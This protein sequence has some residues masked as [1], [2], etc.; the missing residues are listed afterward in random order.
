M[1]PQKYFLA[2]RIFSG[3][4][5]IPK[6]PTPEY[7]PDKYPE[8]SRQYFRISG[9]TR[10]SMLDHDPAKATT[11][12]SLARSRLTTTRPGDGQPGQ[13]PARLTTGRAD[14][15]RR[16]CGNA[17]KVRFWQLTAGH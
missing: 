7:C 5:N 17:Q 10:T 6:T 1:P 2:G 14:H 11:T 3:A 8:H 13:P 15:C 4:A 12:E 16:L 9:F